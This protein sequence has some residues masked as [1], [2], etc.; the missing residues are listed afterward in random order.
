[1]KNLFSYFLIFF[2]SK[3]SLSFDDDVIFLYEL[4]ANDSLSTRILEMKAIRLKFP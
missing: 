3:L 1:M 4:D 2:R